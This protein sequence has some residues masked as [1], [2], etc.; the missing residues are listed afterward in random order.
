MK[1]ILNQSI[2]VGVDTGKFQLDIYLR[3]LDIYFSV[4]NDEKGI[5]EA[6]R[7]LKQYNVERIVIEATGRLEM[8]FI[9]ACAKAR[10]PFVIA[11]PITLNALRVPS[12]NA[13]KQ[14]SSMHN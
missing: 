6:I 13:L 14:I 7:E 3:P 10:L 5:K 9:M 1:N 11:N 4:S 8:A 12:D 2:N